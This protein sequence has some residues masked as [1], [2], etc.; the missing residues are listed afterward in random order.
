[1]VYGFSRV[2]VL[3][4]WGYAQGTRLRILKLGEELFVGAPA[5]AQTLTPRPRHVP[6]GA[7]IGEH[8]APVGRPGSDLVRTALTG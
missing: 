6:Y 7:S 1:M 4:T 3:D 5:G 2:S 8:R